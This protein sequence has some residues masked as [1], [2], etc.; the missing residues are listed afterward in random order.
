M[1]TE[2]RNEL[3]NRMIR[4]YGFE[5]PFVIQFANACES[6]TTPDTCDM[7]DHILETTVLCHEKSPYFSE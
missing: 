6:Y 1:M 3:L 2:F 7:W 5:N 4:I